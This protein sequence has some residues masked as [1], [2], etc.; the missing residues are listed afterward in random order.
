MT[1]QGPQEDEL[2]EISIWKRQS[3]KER[4]GMQGKKITH[5]ILTLDLLA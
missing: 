3:V 1:N 2:I 4:L 5:L